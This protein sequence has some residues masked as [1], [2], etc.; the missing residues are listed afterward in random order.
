MEEAKKKK[1]EEDKKKAEEAEKK[2]EEDERKAADPDQEGI[3][4]NSMVGKGKLKSSYNY[5][6]SEEELLEEATKTKAKTKEELEKEKERRK[7]RRLDIR[8]IEFDWIF[9]KVEGVQFLRTLSE[10][11]SIEI[12][13]LTL[14]RHIIR[15]CWSYY[16][17]S[18]MIFLFIPYMLYISLF[19]FYSTYIH[20][21][22]IEN[23]DGNWS[24][25]GLANSSLLGLIMLFIIYFGYYEVRQILY[26]KLKYFLSVWNLVDLCSLI[27]NSIICIG[28]IS[29]MNEPDVNLLMS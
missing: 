4:K 10:T 2:A 19:V 14:V 15:F 17:T 7:Q 23:G 25:F 16:R 6:D 3:N 27:L 20:K 13:S 22:Q 12:F 29:G 21:K 9:N 5:I 1:E 24:G 28:D 18:I 11:K 26:H 8:A